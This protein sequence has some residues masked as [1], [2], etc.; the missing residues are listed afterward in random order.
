MCCTDC[1]IVL[2]ATDAGDATLHEGPDGGVVLGILTLPPGAQTTRSGHVISIGSG[3]V[4][5]DGTSYTPGTFD[6]E[7]I[8]G[9]LTVPV[10]AQ[11]TLSGYLISAGSDLVVVDGISYSLDSSNCGV[12]LGT[13]TIPPGAQITCSGHAISVSSGIVVIDGISYTLE[14]GGAETL[15]DLMNDIA[16]SSTTPDPS[17]P[18][19]GSKVLSAGQAIGSTQ[20]PFTTVAPSGAN[21]ANLITSAFGNGA[22]AATT[23]H[24]PLS[25]SSPAA[26]TGCASRVQSTSLSDSRLLALLFNLIMCTLIS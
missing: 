7:V 12:S 14:A 1:E 6:G 22:A 9:S 15:Q 23:T 25:R 26:F 2:G 4:N 17:R 8:M 5:A 16:S 13:L 20:T 3:I 18:I 10:G 11:T 24:G 19:K 21:I